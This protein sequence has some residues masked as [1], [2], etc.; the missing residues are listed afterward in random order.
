MTYGP[1]KKEYTWSFALSR[2]LE[3][4]PSRVRL[5]PVP[6]HAVNALR[7]RRRSS[8]GVSPPVRRRR[9]AAAAAAARCRGAA[10]APCFTVG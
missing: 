8:A 3:P 2:V 5:A 4:R 10:G 6:R 9:A 7:A 1:A